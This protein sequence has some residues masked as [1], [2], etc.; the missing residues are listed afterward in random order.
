MTS[1][2]EPP[3]V[4]LFE[5]SDAEEGE[6]GGAAAASATLDW[7]LCPMSSAPWLLLFG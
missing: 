7:D 2:A 5:S 4:R 6:S 3:S 1:A